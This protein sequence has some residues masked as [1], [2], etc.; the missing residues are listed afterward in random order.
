MLMPIGR[1]RSALHESD[2]SRAR[3]LIESMQQALRSKSD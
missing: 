3:K 1:R 2:I